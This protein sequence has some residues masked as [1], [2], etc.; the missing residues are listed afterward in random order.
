MAC[1]EPEPRPG[2][3]AVS[4]SSALTYNRSA[5]DRKLRRVRSDAGSVKQDV[6]EGREIGGEQIG[7][8]WVYEGSA[9]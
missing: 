1:N 7:C 8:R 2:P 5:I 9:S 6:A 4:S 3:A